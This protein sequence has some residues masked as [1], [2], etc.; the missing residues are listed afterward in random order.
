[1]KKILSPLTATGASA[2][3]AKHAPCDVISAT[4]RINSLHPKYESKLRAQG[5]SAEQI[6]LSNKQ[7][8]DDLTPAFTLI[9]TDPNKSCQIA[10]SVSTQYGLN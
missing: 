10:D 2:T 6:S 8:F 5:L 3:K 1:M 4:A 9:Q 7:F